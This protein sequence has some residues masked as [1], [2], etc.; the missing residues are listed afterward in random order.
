MNFLCD[1]FLFFQ[2]KYYDNVYLPLSNQIKQEIA[3][4]TE[5]LDAKLAKGSTS[6]TNND[7]DFIRFLSR[8]IEI[9]DNRSNMRRNLI[10]LRTELELFKVNIEVQ[11]D[12]SETRSNII[13]LSIQV[14]NLL[15]YGTFFCSNA[16]TYDERLNRLKQEFEYFKEISKSNPDILKTID[17]FFLSILY[18]L[19]KLMKIKLGHKKKSSSKRESKVN[20]E[21][22]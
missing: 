6:V 8:L 11:D 15:H 10:Q 4:F 1:R 7:K 13:E 17:K 12:L 22:F 20:E 2:P 14:V 21:D 9:M 19:P 18:K 5:K 16:K 3:L